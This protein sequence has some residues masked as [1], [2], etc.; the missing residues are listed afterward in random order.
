MAEKKAEANAALEDEAEAA[1]PKKKGKLPV[2]ILAVVVLAGGGGAAWWFLKAKQTDPK[3]TAAQKAA[4]AAKPPLYTQLDKDLTTGLTRS[5]A[6]D[7]YL[8]VEIKIKIANEKV[9][10]KIN[11]R[12]PEIRDA[13][14][15]LM[16]SKTSEDLKTVEDKQRLA[17]EMAAQINRVI[18]S[19]KPETDGV[20]GV[21]FTAFMLQ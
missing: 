20:L 2:I 13:L 18:Q 8:Q 10:E 17:A 4:D 11:Q 3:A 14:L 5:D 19:T 6:E 1:P 7:H 16:T 15:L 9:A 21:Y 12:S